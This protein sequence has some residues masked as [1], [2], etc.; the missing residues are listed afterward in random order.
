MGSISIWVT[1]K[2]RRVELLPTSESEDKL[3]IVWQFTSSLS[4]MIPKFTNIHCYVDLAGVDL[5]NFPWRHSG[6]LK[7]V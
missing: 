5:E 6:V 3:R 7:P 2:L 1:P 4:L